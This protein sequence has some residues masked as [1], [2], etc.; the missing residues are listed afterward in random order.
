MSGLSWYNQFTVGRNGE[1]DIKQLFVIV[2]VTEEVEKLRSEVLA[3]REDAWRIATSV[4]PEGVL[5]CLKP[6]DC[7]W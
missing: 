5:G 6:K 3:D 7:P 4:S 2:N 1:L